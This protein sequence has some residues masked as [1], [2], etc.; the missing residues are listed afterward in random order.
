MRP[1]L[2]PRPQLAPRAQERQKRERKRALAKMTRACGEDEQ[3]P[4]RLG[5]LLARVVG[6][7]GRVRAAA[8]ALAV[9]ALVAAI[10][11]A[12]AVGGARSGA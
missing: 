11:V 6:Q 3:K 8:L 2:P 5:A 9:A 10:A 12:V 4:S 7:S 1:T